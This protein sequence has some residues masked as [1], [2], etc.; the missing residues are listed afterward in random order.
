[1][2]ARSQ[3]QPVSVECE[4]GFWEAAGAPSEVVGPNRAQGQPHS[5]AQ[6]ASGLRNCWQFLLMREL[7]K[8]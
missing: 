4:E 2:R 3:T 1:M 6:P 7:C 5:A 8:H